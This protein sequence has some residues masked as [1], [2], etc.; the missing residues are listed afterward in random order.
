MAVIHRRCEGVKD[1]D[2]IKGN[3]LVDQVKH[4]S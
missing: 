1:Y 4:H 3:R 2:L